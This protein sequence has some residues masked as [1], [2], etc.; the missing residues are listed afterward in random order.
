MDTAQKINFHG[1]HYQ[2]ETVIKMLTE[3]IEHFQTRI[4]MLERSH[5]DK[6]K[7]LLKT[8]EEMVSVRKKIR[9]DL[10]SLANKANEF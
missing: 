7:Q 3:E 9:S 6:Q 5:I 2:V 10:E 8:Y 1:N 4:D